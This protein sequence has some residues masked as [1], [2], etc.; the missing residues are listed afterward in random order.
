MLESGEEPRNRA[1]F[2]ISL[3]LLSVSGVVMVAATGILVFRRHELIRRKLIHLL[4]RM[5][6]SNT[7]DV[8]QVSPYLP[9]RL[10]E[11]TRRHSQCVCVI[12]AAA[13]LDLD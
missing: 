8:Y 10:G 1:V 9:T 12:A 5:D 13:A 6:T 2:L 3:L 4:G 7:A 11:A